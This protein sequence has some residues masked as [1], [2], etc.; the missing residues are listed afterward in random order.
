MLTSTKFEREDGFAPENMLCYLVTSG[1]GVA[2][3][4]K[5]LQEDIEWD[6]GNSFAH[7]HFTKCLKGNSILV[8]FAVYTILYSVR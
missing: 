4:P 1:V 5:I 7:Q 8:V 2:C 6:N 3:H